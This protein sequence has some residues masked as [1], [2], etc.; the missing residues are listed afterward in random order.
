MTGRS[1]RGWLITHA[2]GIV[3][4][5]RADGCMNWNT[6]FIKA[7]DRRVDSAMCRKRKRHSRMSVVHLRVVLWTF[8]TVAMMAPIRTTVPS[9]CGSM[10]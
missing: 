1:G 4:I 7:M 8:I 3:P 9:R 5:N 10:V 6:R 2:A